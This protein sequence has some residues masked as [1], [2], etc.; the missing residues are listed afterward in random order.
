MDDDVRERLAE[1]LGDVAIVVSHPDGR[2]EVDWVLG[3]VNARAILA[4]KSSHL[5]EGVEKPPS[6]YGANGVGTFRRTEPSA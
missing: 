4:E 5:P 3:R 2:Y 6:A 1:R